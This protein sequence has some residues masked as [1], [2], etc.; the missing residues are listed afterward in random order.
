MERTFQKEKNDKC[1]PA[2][3][4]GRV[5]R[6]EVKPAQLEHCAWQGG[7][8][9]SFEREAG[10]DQAGLSGHSQSLNAIL[11]ATGALKGF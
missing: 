1:K 9:A 5:P 3:K 7:E 6:K 2:E 11:R 10:F 4:P 8:A